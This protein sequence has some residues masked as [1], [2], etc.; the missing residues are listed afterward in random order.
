TGGGPEYACRTYRLPITPVEL[1]ARKGPVYLALA[2]EHVTAR[3]GARAALERLRPAYRTAVATNSTRAE[4]DLI[5]ARI[6]VEGLLDA[7]VARED[8]VRAT[9]APDAYL[10][11]AAAL[12]FAPAECVVVEDTQR[13]ARAGVAAGMPVI[14]A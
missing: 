4:V 12:G 3:A 8:Y 6:G 5:L 11:A 7:V 9:P 14:A 1:R 2:A 13:G 10:A